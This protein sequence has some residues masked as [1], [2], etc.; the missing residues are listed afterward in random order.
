MPVQLETPEGLATRNLHVTRRTVGALVG[1]GA[2]AAA[3]RP[4][5]ASALHTDLD[6]I[7]EEAVK[8]PVGDTQ[9]PGYIAK[10]EGDGPFAVVLVAHEI[11][12]LH[13]YIKDVAR[14]LAKAGYLAVA[15]DLYARAG[16]P[17][18]LTDW[19]QIR[20]IV[21]TA[22]YPQVMSDLTHTVDWLAAARP[23]ANTQRLGVTGFCWGG[24]VVWRFSA[25]DARVK[26]GAAF[27]GRLRDPGAGNYSGDAPEPWPMDEAGKFHGPVI[28]FY[29]AKDRGIPVAD[30]KAMQE[31]LA[32]AGGASKIVLYPDA[33]HGFH[34]D[35]RDSYVEADAK[36]AW[37]KALAWFRDHGVA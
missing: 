32:D 35:Y 19:D 26:A 33:G 22:T 28:G 5:A 4:V 25:Y 15:P 30:V 7:T 21:N 23:D 14:R 13:A 9:L 6:G 24:A 12:G 1:L 18:T 37:T 27:Y 17:S 16:D 8:I 20:A 31:K 10:P 11:F 3:V 29:G 34:A 2:F 36:D